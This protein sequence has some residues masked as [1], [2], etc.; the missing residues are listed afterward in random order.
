MSR[1]HHY[2]SFLTG[3]LLGGVLGAAAVFLTAV[4]TGRTWLNQA[5]R[6]S[7]LIKA[8]G[9]GLLRS[10]Y[11]RAIA[12]REPHAGRMNQAEDEHMIPIPIDYVRRDVQ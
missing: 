2:S 10:A 11:R 4:P 5:G 1:Q 6:E 7:M 8:K 9:N 12:L 3:V